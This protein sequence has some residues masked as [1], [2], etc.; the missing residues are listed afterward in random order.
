QVLPAY[1]YLLYDLQ[2][3]LINSERSKEANPAIPLELPSRALA[4]GAGN[5]ET[6]ALIYCILT[7]QFQHNT[8]ILYAP[9]YSQLL[10]GAEKRDVTEE[11]LAQKYQTNRYRFEKYD[12]ISITW[13]KNR[14]LIGELT[15]Q[16]YIGWARTPLRDLQNWTPFTFPRYTIPSFFP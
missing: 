14:Y 7:S 4:K 6:L 15:D 16:I 11:Q 12:G 9:K 3:I 5:I 1:E 10:V 8:M 2:T 13:Y